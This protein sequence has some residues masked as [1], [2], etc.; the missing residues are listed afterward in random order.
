MNNSISIT[1]SF[2]SGAV[3]GAAV[4]YIVTKKKYQKEL[5]DQIAPVRQEFENY[6]K[7]EE[8]K[9]EEAKAAAEKE[10]RARLERERKKE[11]AKKL[12]DTV[13]EL[14][15]AAQKRKDRPYI[16]EQGGEEFG[17]Y[18]AVS[19]EYY[20]DGVLLDNT[21]VID[22]HQIDS[23]VGVENL[24]LLDEHRPLIWVRNEE[25]KVDYEIAYI[26]ED[27]YAND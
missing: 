9:E 7:N 17:G 2:L 4:A 20:T 13:K 6:M 26:D 14:D 23:L 18:M 19:L 12:A 10:E 25:M 21:D 27:F 3:V 24:A 1:I 15:Y 11:E 16:I 22:D 8:K 5:E